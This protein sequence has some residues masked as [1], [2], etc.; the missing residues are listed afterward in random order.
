MM[1]AETAIL[2]ARFAS[3]DTSSLGG[4]VPIWAASLR[5]LGD[6]WIAG[7]GLNTYG[8]ATLFYPAVVPGY[9]LREA[10]NDYLQIAVEGGLLMAVPIVVAA[11]AFAV[12]VRRRFL[13]PRADA[14]YWTRLGAV[15]GI[16][17]IAIQSVVEFSLQM[18]GNAALFSVLCAVALHD[19]VPLPDRAPLPDRSPLPIPSPLPTTD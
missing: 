11:I 5:M 13:T 17:A 3:A 6:F 2:A 15:T 19:R 16:V 10:H 12:A 1:W 4:R 9:H 7:S 8:V 14:S 18:P